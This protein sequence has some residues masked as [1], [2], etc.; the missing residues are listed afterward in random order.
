MWHAGPK[1]T[2]GDNAY[3]M[4]VLVV[5]HGYKMAYLNAA[6]KIASSRVD[7]DIS[8]NLKE[9]NRKAG[10]PTSGKKKTSPCRLKGS[11]FYSHSIPEPCLEYPLIWHIWLDVAMDTQTMKIY[12]N[13]LGIW[14]EVFLIDLQATKT[15]R[16]QYINHLPAAF[17]TTW[18]LCAE[19][20]LQPDCSTINCNC[21][22]MLKVYTHT[23]I[24]TK[25]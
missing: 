16:R 2:S 24:Y 8:L 10:W 18:P 21:I 11:P 20:V 5:N 4:T 23:W 14:P 7:D 1:K 25:I 15:K 3:E 9:K 13:H 19:V 12:E 22:W 17:P 6:H